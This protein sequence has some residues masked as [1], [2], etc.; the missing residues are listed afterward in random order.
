M[1]RYPNWKTNK[2]VT[3]AS[4]SIRAKADG[5]GGGHQAARKMPQQTLP[6]RKLHISCQTGSILWCYR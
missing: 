3:E 1:Y 2:Q 5:S 4:V 6:L